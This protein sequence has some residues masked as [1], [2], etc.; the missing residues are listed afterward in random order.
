MQRFDCQHPVKKEK[1]AQADEQ[2]RKIDPFPIPAPS[3]EWFV[4]VPPPDT[5]VRWDE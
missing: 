5:V 3:A 2:T 4:F 1:S